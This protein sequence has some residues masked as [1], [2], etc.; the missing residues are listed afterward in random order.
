[1]SSDRA[2]PALDAL[3]GEELSSALLVLGSSASSL[4]DDA[5][6][7]ATAAQVLD[8][9]PSPRSDLEEK[10]AALIEARAAMDAAQ[11]A[12]SDAT[13]EE[14]LSQGSDLRRTVAR[15]SGRV[16]L[17]RQGEALDALLEEVRWQ[18]PD[19]CGSK[20][21]ERELGRLA[22][23]TSRMAAII[24]PPATPQTVEWY[25]PEAGQRELDRGRDDRERRRHALREAL[26]DAGKGYAD[27][28]MEGSGTFDWAIPRGWRSR[29]K[30]LDAVVQS[31]REAVE[32]GGEAWRAERRKERET[33]AAAQRLLDTHDAF[34]AADGA[35]A[36][37]EGAERSRKAVVAFVERWWEQ[38]CAE[39]RPPERSAAMVAIDEEPSSPV[40]ATRRKS[41]QPARRTNVRPVALTLDQLATDDNL[42]PAGVADPSAE[43][44]RLEAAGL[45]RIGRSPF[46][47]SGG[48][49]LVPTADGV[50]M[51]EDRLDQE[52]QLPGGRSAGKI[53]ALRSTT[54]YGKE[55]IE[56]RA[57]GRWGTTSYDFSGSGTTDVGGSRAP[58]LDELAAV[59]V[60]EQLVAAGFREVDGAEGQLWS[61]TVGGARYFVMVVDG[62]MEGVYRS[63]DCVPR[64]LPAGCKI[65]GPGTAK[66]T[67]TTWS[68]SIE[69]GND[70]MVGHLVPGPRGLCA[71]RLLR[72][73]TDEELGLVRPVVERDGFRAGA[74]ND[75][76]DILRRTHL[77]GIPVGDLERRMQPQGAVSVSG[78][79]LP[80]QRLLPVIARTTAV[81]Q[82]AGVTPQEVARPL[83][84]ALRLQ[85]L[86][87]L[88]WQQPI[89]SY[90][91]QTYEYEHL[92]ELGG[93]SS[94]FDDGTSGRSRHALRNPRTGEEVTFAGLVPEMLDRWSFAEGPGVEY[95]VPVDQIIRTVDHLR[96]RATDLDAA[97][98]AGERIPIGGPMTGNGAGRAAERP[99][100]RPPRSLW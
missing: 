89:F 80:G 84:R 25:L 99:A 33:G 7:G 11:G 91:G 56:L 86:G 12:W 98:R 57:T 78:F 39:V 93:Q 20:E 29:S 65:I 1:M 49:L 88:G 96:A 48:F 26:K 24:D 5:S 47:R 18:A 22:T 63:Y 41:V 97:V 27:L 55:S 38:L 3:A 61:R 70:W 13:G 37:A 17:E 82:A 43:G 74:A 6:A 68:R 90:E 66:T 92:A 52:H 40:R 71:G 60:G 69:V 23:L 59:P 8:R 94:P 95:H 83:R 10:E 77:N 15:A 30:R 58:G 73:P 72:E 64:S 62:G 14:D 87:L 34:V 42:L 51:F 67:T 75:V 32:G 79:L 100:T 9:L 53:M 4:L 54:K 44:A 45:E 50:R 19:R 76:E 31:L 36:S 21:L 81:C 35:N 28:R 16:R 85:E 2:T 46:L